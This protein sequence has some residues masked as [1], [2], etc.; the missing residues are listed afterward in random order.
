MFGF[1][2]FVLAFSGVYCGHL[3][4]PIPKLTKISNAR[5]TS[6]KLHKK[7]KVQQLTITESRD[8]KTF[9]A[10]FPPILS[11]SSLGIL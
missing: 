2:F 10:V 8:G 6:S 11:S 3:A 5:T 4:V 7:R 9:F 1:A